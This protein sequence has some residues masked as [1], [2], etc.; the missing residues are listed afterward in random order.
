MIAMLMRDQNS[1]KRIWIFPQHGHPARGFTS[2][3]ARVH[4]HARPVCDQ[5]YRVTSRAAAQYGDLHKLAQ[6]KSLSQATAIFHLSFFI[7]DLTLVL[8]LRAESEQASLRNG[9]WLDF[10]TRAIDGESVQVAQ[11]SQRQ[12]SRVKATLRDS[13]RVFRRHCFNPS[14]DLF[15]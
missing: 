15:G 12:G 5:Q 1:V 7:C 6:R 8:D 14:N 2:A 13:L 11:R 4:Q 10:Q 9:K 3:E